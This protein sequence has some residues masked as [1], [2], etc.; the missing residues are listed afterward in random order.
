MTAR[1]ASETLVSCP[2]ADNGRSTTV[3]PDIN[4]PANALVLYLTVDRK[5]SY[6]RLA[7]ASGSGAPGAGRK[8]AA[9]TMARDSVMPSAEL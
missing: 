1:K 6:S 5:P 8:V 2:G 3:K 4:G 9:A 7:S